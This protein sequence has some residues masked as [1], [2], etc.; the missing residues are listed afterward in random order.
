MLCEIC[1]GNCLEQILNIPS[2]TRADIRKN[3][4][5]L[6]NACNTE[7]DA[8][9]IHIAN[10]LWLNG[11]FDIEEKSI[12]H[13]SELFT[14]VY[15]SNADMDTFSKALRC[16]LNDNTKGLLKDNIENI[17]FGKD[18]LASIVSCIYLSVAW[19]N[20]FDKSKTYRG[21]FHSFNGD[22]AAQYMQEVSPMN[23]YYADDFQ[24]I[25]KGVS[26]GGN[27]WFVLP[28]ESVAIKDMVSK[29]EFLNIVTN[30]NQWENTQYIRV[31]L[32][33]P[34]FDIKCDFDLK[35][36]L[37]NMGITDIF[38]ASRAD[39]SPLCNNDNFF[40]DKVENS[41][42]LKIDED[43]IEGT[44]YSIMS[45]SRASLLPDDEKEFIL[46]RP[47]IFALTNSDNAIMLMGIINDID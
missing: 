40:I 44:S 35:S 34:K 27:M 38:D 12:S 15:K 31:N 5:A 2:F 32:S 33:V 37:Q 24:C 30:P 22:I 10:S 7:S 18:T 13:M 42:R 8:A 47:F 20:K 43:G 17:D 4:K 46:D 16:W 23:I 36:L 11:A 19:Y 21:I 14:Q 9:E 28:D 41:S 26:N 29:S 6:Y 3:A 25:V 1:A 45:I 39:F